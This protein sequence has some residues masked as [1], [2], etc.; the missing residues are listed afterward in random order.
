MSSPVIAKIQLGRAMRRLRDDAGKSRD[1][2]AS[3]LDCDVSK[4]SRIEQGKGSLKTLEVEALLW[5]YEAP[6]LRD[7]LVET[8]RLARKRTAYQV[9]PWQRDFVGM[10]AEARTI[11]E[12]QPEVVPA[13]LQTERYARAVLAADPR[14]APAEVD[15]YVGG[16]LARQ[17]RLAEEVPP[18]LRMVLSEGAIRRSVGGPAVHRE[19]LLWLRKF[20]E[21]PSVDLRVLPFS[22]GAHAAMGIG[23]V[24]LELPDPEVRIG[25][26]ETL[27]SAD[28]L[29]EPAQLDR[30]AELFER[31]FDSAADAEQ[32]A[33]LCAEVIGQLD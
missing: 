19:Q 28:Y 23:F 4:I 5:L 18:R 6:D 11:L 13:L 16:R 29:T 30:Y 24:V 20:A 10:E 32:T 21:R 1:E 26:V 25:Y 8:A 12:Y 3:A 2:A 31:L 22:A 14:R 27:D 15:R 33:A 9:P 17:Q 7:Q